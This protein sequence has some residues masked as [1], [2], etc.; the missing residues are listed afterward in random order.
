ML[1]W[2]SFY[3]TE[4]WRRWCLWRGWWEWV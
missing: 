1:N 2:H 3:N 4:R